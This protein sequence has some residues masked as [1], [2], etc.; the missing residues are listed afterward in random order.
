MKKTDFMKTALRLAKKGLNR[1]G[2]NPMVG[3]VIVKNNKIIGKGFHE[4]FGGSHAE[5][6]AI[7]N[8]EERGSSVANSTMFVTFE[9]C[10]HFKKKTP[11]CAQLIA[12]KGIKKVVISMK[13]PNPKVNGRGIKFLKKNQIETEVGTYE[14]ESKE[15]NKGFASLIK[16]K[17]PFVTLKICTS[18]DGKIYDIGGNNDNIGDRLQRKHANEL[19]K[20]FD[21]VLVGVNTIIRDNPQLNYRGNR[22]NSIQQP[23]P[24]VLDSY[25]RTPLTSKIVIRGNRPIIFTKISPT[26]K[27][28]K[29][30]VKAGCEIVTL[31]V[32]DPKKILKKLPSLGIQRVLIEGGGKI[33][34]NFLESK[35]WDE[36]IIYYSPKFLGEAGLSLTHN[37][38]TKFLIN[39]NSEIKVKRV[40]RCL[41]LRIK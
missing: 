19:R 32:L 10:C 13:D 14:V 1:T 7:N 23:R 33:F 8:A 29:A 20:E 40:G 6:N 12:K 2:S 35:L 39:Q 15:L 25:L 27:K 11:P 36:L 26:S 18:M 38:R 28:F 30:L 21:S 22:K 37:L 16:K 5:V 34:S 41:M 4:K 24:I 17:R 9:P 3:A 31:D